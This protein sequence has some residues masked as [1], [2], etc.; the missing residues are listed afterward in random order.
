MCCGVLMGLIA[1]WV[2]LGDLAE[3]VNVGTLFAFAIVCTG[4]IVLRYTDPDTPRPFKTPGAPLVP[5]LGILSCLY[6][7][8]NLP[9]VTLLRFVVW[10][11][12]GMI[13]YFMFSRNNSRLSPQ[14]INI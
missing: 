13:V 8:V 5:F 7:M 14:K 11:A 3:L 4:V 2:P 6:L 10:M 1:G 9:W 12:I